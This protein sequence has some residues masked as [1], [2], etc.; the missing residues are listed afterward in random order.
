MTSAPLADDDLFEAARLLF[1][2]RSP[3]I[4][5]DL[6]PQCRGERRAVV[7]HEVQVQDDAYGLPLAILSLTVESVSTRTAF[8]ARDRVITDVQT[9]GRRRSQKAWGYHRQP[10]VENAVFR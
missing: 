5:F 6:G 3:A 2:G 10:R 4:E 9:L 1:C 8:E 7:V